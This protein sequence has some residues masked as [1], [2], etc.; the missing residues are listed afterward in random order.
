MTSAQ[1]RGLCVKHRTL[2]YLAPTSVFSQMLQIAHSVKHSA[3]PSSFLPYVDDCPECET[4]CT[5]RPSVSS[6]MLLIAHSVRQKALRDLSFL[7]NVTDCS[8]CEAQGPSATP[9]R[10]CGGCRLLRV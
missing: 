3:L 4:K 6:Q 9:K 2:L 1:L 5:T 8:E 7:L 10:I